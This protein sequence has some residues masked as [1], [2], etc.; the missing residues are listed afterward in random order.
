MNS[1]KQITA[2]PWELRRNNGGEEENGLQY[3]QNRENLLRLRNFIPCAIKSEVRATKREL[4][5]WI[6]IIPNLLNHGVKGQIFPIVLHTF[7]VQ[8]VRGFD[9]M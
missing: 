7:V 5:S 2:I 1:P 6:K 3:E 4:L 9:Q 8:L